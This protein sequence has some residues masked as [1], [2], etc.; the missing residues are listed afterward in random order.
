MNGL[1]PTLIQPPLGAEG[2][3]GLPYE[4]C[5]SILQPLLP[6]GNYYLL[7]GNPNCD[8]E[9]MSWHY[10]KASIILIPLLRVCRQ[11]REIGLDIL[12]SRNGFVVVL[13][14]WKARVSTAIRTRSS[15]ARRDMVLAPYF[16]R[17]R[18]LV[19]YM[20]NMNP[21]LITHPSRRPLWPSLVSNLRSVVLLPGVISTRYERFPRKTDS[22]LVFQKRQLQYLDKTLPKECEITICTDMKSEC[23]P[24]HYRSMTSRPQIKGGHWHNSLKFPV[25]LLR[26]QTELNP[27]EV[28]VLQC[29]STFRKWYTLRSGEMQLPPGRTHRVW[30]MGLY[31]AG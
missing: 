23:Q 24:S 26:P 29:C 1:L 28:F 21:K 19:I 14:Q 22:D 11:L 27:P 20:F 18:H 25:Y 7:L 5:Q 17:I 10:K 15:K 31:L 4:I 9:C 2:L 30:Y 6:E 16:P 13:E 3:P 8:F 12:F